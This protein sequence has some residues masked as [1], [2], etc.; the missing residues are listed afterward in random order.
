MV[1]LVLGG[2]DDEHAVGVLGALR[3]RGVR[4]EML[5]SRLFPG[6]IRLAW[7]PLSD[8][9]HLTLPDRKPIDFS[10]IRSVYWRCYNGFTAPMLGDED[11]A[12]L[13]LNDARSL[14]ESLLVHLP[15]RWVNGWDAYQ[16]HQ[17]K[18]AALA[19]VAA[20]TLP[21][22]LRC[23]ATCLGNDPQAIRQFV[24]R[25]PRCIFKP[26][27]GGAH[28]AMVTESHLTDDNLRSL[29]TAPV[30]IQEHVEGTDVRVFVADQRVLACEIVTDAT[31]FRDDDQ[32]AIAPVDL[33][34]DLAAAC[35]AIARTLHLVWT[36]IDLRRTGEGR[37]VFLEAN[38]SPMFIGFEFYS[39]LPLTEALIGVLTA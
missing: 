27:Q 8:A 37:Y 18:P 28:T 38:P 3:A 36:G 35:V 34:P 32:A 23:P 25:H 26:V 17:T 20:M 31:D 12:E 2:D 7:D 14:F 13:A 21:A 30:T 19:R 29:T 10:E 9:G 16:L 24:A 6:D 5:D 15:A 4:A 1:V 11:Q 39:G 22:T 33:P